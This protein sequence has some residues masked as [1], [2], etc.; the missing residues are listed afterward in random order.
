MKFLV[1]GL[2]SMGKRRIRNLQHLKA[3]EIVGFDLREDRRKE[4]ADKYGIETFADFDE[5]MAT[6]PQAMVISTPPDMHM[7]F[8]IKAVSNNIHFFAEAGTSTEGIEEVIKVSKQNNVVAAPSC[9]LRYHP[10]IKKMKELIDAGAIGKI[11]TYTY[12]SGQYLPDWHP[13]EDYRT[14]YVSRRE[15]GACREIVPFELTWV[16]WI[17]GEVETVT[18]MKGK[19]SDLDCDIDDA[20]HLLM[21]YKNGAIGHLLVDV[22]ARAAVRNCRFIGSE[23]TLEW[24]ASEKKV[25][26]YN[27]ATKEWTDF[28]EPKA[29]IEEG[30]SEMSA[31]NMYI[32]EMEAFVNAANGKSPYPHSYEEDLRTLGILFAAEKSSDSLTQQPL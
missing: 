22:L 9:T 19:L 20:Y 21:R 15:T 4:A 1:V 24:V 7:Q 26:H 14:F 31:E 32:E 10:S 3:G 29:I 28:L 25:R 13:W 12:E 27:A 16:N 18:G 6:G 5:A 17:V 2:G 30:Y 8:G 11:L 23:G